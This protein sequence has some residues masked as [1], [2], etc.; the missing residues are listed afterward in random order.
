MITLEPEVDIEAWDAIA[1]AALATACAEALV[2]IDPPGLRAG[3]AC[4]VFADDEAVRALNRDFRAKDA[5]TNVLSFP[6]DTSFPGSEMETDADGPR[7][8]DVILGYETCAREAA[9]RGISLADHAAHLVLHGVLHLLGYDHTTEA[10]AERM[11]AIERA[12]LQRLGIADP[13]ALDP[14]ETDDTQQ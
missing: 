12:A 8:G 13:Y 2:T 7:L 11:E 3:A 6:A 9:E 1:P 4:V 5:P 10:E 14:L